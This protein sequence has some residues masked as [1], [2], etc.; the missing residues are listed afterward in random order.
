MGSKKRFFRI[1]VI[2]AAVVLAIVLVQRW[3]AGEAVERRG[4][5]MGDKVVKT[6]EQWREQLTP[7]QFQ[8][9][10]RKG[11]ERAFTGQY[12]NTKD[13]GI[14]QCICCGQPLFDAQTKFDSGTGWP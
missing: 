6:E 12:Y 8:V 5:P 11:T 7:E 4:V 9:T 2:I 13:D 10:R 14:Y 3:S 1:G